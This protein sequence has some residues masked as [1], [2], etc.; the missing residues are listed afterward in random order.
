[1]IALPLHP[2]PFLLL[3][4]S[5]LV[6]AKPSPDSNPHP[7]AWDWQME[8]QVEYAR[9]NIYEEEMRKLVKQPYFAKVKNKINVKKDEVALLPCRVKNMGDGFMVSDENYIFHVYTLFSF[10]AT[11]SL[12]TSLIASLVSNTLN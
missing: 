12:S 8:E 9:F 3:L 10:L 1:M 11:L 7:T 5:F 4:L 6:T 2:T